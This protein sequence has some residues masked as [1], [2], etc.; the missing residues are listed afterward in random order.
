MTTARTGRTLTARM[1][2]APGIEKSRDAADA[3]IEKLLAEGLT[4]R[5]IA[6]G[7][8]VALQRRPVQGFLQRNPEVAD[9][10]QGLGHLLRAAGRYGGSR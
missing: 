8:G 7:F 6:A 2:L 10:A 9:L 4:L 5:E 3:V 1:A